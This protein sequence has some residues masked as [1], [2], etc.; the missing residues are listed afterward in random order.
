M[1]E[2]NRIEQLK[3]FITE[4]P[5][6]VFLRY[7]LGLEYFHSGQDEEAEKEFL[8]VMEIKDDYLPVYYQLGKLYEVK[9]ENQKA[10]EFY[11]KGIEIAELQRNFKTLNELRGAMEELED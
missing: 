8:K 5:L 4:D 2:K 11:K 10:I 3:E 7:A 1:T 9:N 6:D